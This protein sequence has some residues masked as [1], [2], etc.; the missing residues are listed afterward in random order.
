MFIGTWILALC[1]HINHSALVFNIPSSSQDFSTQPELE[2]LNEG[3][4]KTLLSVKY[5]YNKHQYIPKFDTKIKSLDGKR[6]RI[7]G[8]M[9]PL[10]ETTTHSFFML[11]YYPINICFFCGG[12]GPESVVE[13]SSAKP[14]KFSSEPMT[15]EGT[16]KLNHADPDRLFFILLGAKR[17]D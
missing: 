5:T 15:L 16:L 8:F 9:Y 12:A 4:W 7:K 6:I 1:L 3:I 2:I 14:I 11:S 13:V 17:V 10:E